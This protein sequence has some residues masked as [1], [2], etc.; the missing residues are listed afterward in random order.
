MTLQLVVIHLIDSYVLTQPSLYVSAL[1]LAL[2]SMLQMDLP[3]LNVLTKID[4]LINYPPLPL[5]LEFYTEAMGLEYLL[6]LL[7]AEKPVLSMDP[8]SAKLDKEGK[9]DED[10]MDEDNAQEPEVIFILL[11]L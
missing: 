9:L 2:R 7:D 1:L 5:D 3:H 11:L 6:P 10:K 8:P 4:N